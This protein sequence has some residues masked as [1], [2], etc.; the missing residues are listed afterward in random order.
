M[1]PV[2]GEIRKFATDDEARASGYIPIAD[3]ELERVRAMTK[4]QRRAWAALKRDP[5][6]A[7]APRLMAV[8]HNRHES[9]ADRNA[10]KRQRRSR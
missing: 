1:H 6:G 4:E 8:A 7:A 9:K 10:L 3:G 5:P 2:T